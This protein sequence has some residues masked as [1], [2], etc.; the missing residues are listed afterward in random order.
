MRRA[1]PRFFQIAFLAILFFC[2][3][4]NRVFEVSATT[5]VVVIMIS[6]LSQVFWILLKK[7]AR[8]SVL[9]ALISAF[10]ILLLCRARSL[11][12]LML[13][14]L[15]SICGKFVLCVGGKHFINP[16]NF[17]ILF[18]ILLTERAWISPGQ[19][20][21]GLLIAGWV[22][23]LGLVVVIRSARLDT[24]LVFLVTYSLLLG[25]RV[26]YLGQLPAIWLHQLSS[27]TLILFSF[28][29]ITDPRSTPDDPRGRVVFAVSVAILSFYLRFWQQVPAAPLW[30]LFFLS[31]LTLV[32]DKIWRHTRFDWRFPHAS[33]RVVSASGF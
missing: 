2:G 16:A 25:A 33:S 5:A 28:F 3:M 21:S 32:L 18:T 9:S 20:G 26:Y 17:G 31:P 19:W 12:I 22:G 13:V 14:S 10:S 1:D 15:V 24:A 27:G 7:A 4:W 6:V 11:E 29:M 8:D 23:V 30:S